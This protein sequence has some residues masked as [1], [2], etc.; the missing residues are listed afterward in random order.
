MRWQVKGGF[1]PTIKKSVVIVVPHTSNFDFIIGLFARRISRTQINY[2]GKKELF[3]WPFGWY[4]RWTGGVP[5][6]RTQGQ[7]KV[8]AIADVF[9]KQQEFRLALAPEG[10]RKKV[11]KW[12]TGFYYI[13][14]TANVPII[15]VSFDYG[16]KTVNIHPAFYLSGSIEEDL[17]KLESFYTGVK[18]KAD[19]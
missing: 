7:N 10:T 13:A 4:F 15:P 9:S 14:K 19:L 16:T 18:G 12:K 1:N 11:E 3:R 5:L 2:L 17:P 8:E 6:D